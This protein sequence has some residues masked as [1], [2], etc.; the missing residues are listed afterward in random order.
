MNLKIGQ[1]VR[2]IPLKDVRVFGFEDDKSEKTGVITYINVPHRWFLVEYDGLGC[3][4]RSGYKFSDIGLTVFINGCGIKSEEPKHGGKRRYNPH[5]L[6]D[7]EKPMS[8]ANYVALKVQ[9]MRELGVKP[10]EKEWDHLM[11]LDSEIK[12]D[13][14]VRT[15]LKKRWA[16]RN[17]K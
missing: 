10:T 7:Y 8:L 16:Q 13:N 2:F 11:S 17:Y 5:A 1:K 15:I 9:I 6:K 4:L 12:V 14:E 3:K